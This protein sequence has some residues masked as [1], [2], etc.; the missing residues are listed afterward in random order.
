[1]KSKL[2]GGIIIFLAVLPFV[3]VRF[4]QKGG[5]SDDF[6]SEYEPRLETSID[7]LNALDRHSMSFL[8]DKES[9]AIFANSRYSEE[10]YFKCAENN[11]MGRELICTSKALEILYNLNQ[12]NRIT[13]SRK[14]QIV[15]Y[16]NLV[17]EQNS[18]K[19]W[20]GPEQVNSYVMIYKYLNETL[21]SKESIESTLQKSLASDNG[22]ASFQDPLVGDIKSTYFAVKI[23]E[24][25]SYNFTDS[26]TAYLDFISPR[27][28]SLEIGELVNA[29]SILDILKVP[30]D[31]SLKNKMSCI[32]TF[33]NPFTTTSSKA[34]CLELLSTGG[35]NV[36]VPVVMLVVLGIILMY[37]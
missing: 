12:M 21:P 11:T 37:L 29:Y 18:N 10:G 14:E 19:G 3:G 26:R 1:M 20:F 24:Q 25:L 22:Y 7:I 33:F 4:A 34:V 13:L 23:M 9:L 15:R 36:F 8:V 6:L 17:Y 5:W 2:I 31:V 30:A 27:I 32:F 16:A 35:I 28:S